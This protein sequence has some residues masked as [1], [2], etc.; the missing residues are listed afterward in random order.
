MKRESAQTGLAWPVRLGRWPFWCALLLG[1]L[2][3]AAVLACAHDRANRRSMSG[4]AVSPHSLDD[5]VALSSLTPSRISVAGVNLLCGQGLTPGSEPNIEEDLSTLRAWA[6][7][8]RSETDRHFYRFE[9]NPAEFEHS[10]GYFRMLMLTVVLAEDFGVHYDEQRKAGPAQIA[11]DDGFFAEPRSVFLHGLLGPERRGT[12]SSMPVL[13]VAVGRELGYPLKLVTTKG[14]LFVRW[15]GTGERFNI[16]ATSH[17]L[18]RFED[19]YYRH[20]PLE[21]SSEE[22]AAEGYLKSQTPPEEL[23]V[24]LSIRGMCLKQAGRLPEAVASFAAAARL[25]SGCRSYRSME[26]SLRKHV[27]EIDAPSEARNSTTVMRNQ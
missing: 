9:R 3:C 18:C 7:R 13:Y 2:L 27:I 6:S 12:C 8:V 17:G 20:W 5:L 1:V 4:P 24:F 11:T 10:E 26:A 15:E 23:A 14:H 19:D 21:V 16:E 25:A 22:E